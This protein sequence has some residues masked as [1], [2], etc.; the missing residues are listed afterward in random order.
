MILPPCSHLSKCH[1]QC[2]CV[3]PTWKLGVT[4]SISLAHTACVQPITRLCCFP[5]FCVYL[6]WS[7]LHSSPRSPHLLPPLFHHTSFNMYSDIP[8]YGN[9]KHYLKYKLDYI[10]LGFK[11]LQ[12]LCNELRVILRILNTTDFFCM[13]LSLNLSPRFPSQ[14]LPAP[15]SLTRPPH[16]CLPRPCSLPSPCT[17]SPRS[18]AW[19]QVAL[20]AMTSHGTIFWVILTYTMFMLVLFV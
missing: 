5:L 8:Y 12:C 2:V 16:A 11:I 18:N 9:Q 15:C 14:L 3:S 19:P 6:K 7:S 13:F 10:I 4:I 17:R 20:L 1:F